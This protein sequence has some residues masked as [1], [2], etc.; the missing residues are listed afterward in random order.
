MVQPTS[1]EQ[2][3]L[4]LVNRARANPSAEASRYGISLNQ[5][6][7]AGTLSSTAKQPLAFNV[8]L[9]A[10]ARSHSQWMLDND[11]FSHTGTGGSNATTRMQQA[12]YSF[13]G[14]WGSGENL[15]WEGSTGALNLTATITAANQ[16]LFLSPE[17]RK[18]I[19]ADNFREIG[20]GAVQGLFSSN[21]V[22]YNALMTT[23]NYAVSG[24]AVFL[25]GVAF[26]DSVLDDDFYSVG[27]GLNQVVVDAV[28]S[29]GQ[30]FTTQTFASGGYQLALGA[31][32]YTITFSSPS[33]SQSVQKS[34]TIGNQNVKVDLALDPGSQVVGPIDP[35]Q[36]GASHPDL[37][38]VFGF[39]PT[40]FT[41]HYNN[42]GLFEGRSRDSF[43]EL[44]YLA[45][46]ADLRAV[47][48]SNLLAA[49][50][51]YIQFGHAE[52]RSLDHFDEGRYLASNPDL[53][54]FFGYNLTAVTQHYVYYGASEGRATQTFDA[55]AYL[56]RY[57]D[58]RAVFGNDLGAA[59]RH[60]IEY[61]IQEGRT[62]L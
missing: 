44:S 10:S 4:E 40:A 21:G 49:T 47:F 11:V 57:A 1:Q 13:T 54:Q 35:F 42:Y 43:D 30:H 18:N 36:Y 58:L 14:V 17:H 26:Y 34:V 25:T 38:Q 28:R 7:S 51:H 5:G 6:L 56:N 22:T 39:N 9:M 46:H 23:Q 60:Y 53:I 50:Q 24:S 2:Y 3:L 15:A 62:W 37:I 33:L 31:G 29:D 45:S 27:E 32:S 61:G 55:T 41:Q 48:G 20:I 8:H 59:T 16:G 52:G 19:L 12:G